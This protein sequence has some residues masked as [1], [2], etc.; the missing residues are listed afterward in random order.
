M[1]NE[2]ILNGISSTEFPGLLIQTLPP[3]VK[4]KM[5]SNIETIDG[6]DGDM[7]TV[8][9][10]SSYEKEFLIGLSYKYN[11]DDIIA[12]LN[13]H[14][15]V[16]FSNE[17]GKYYRYQILEQIDFEKLIRFK[18][19]RVKMHVQPFKYSNVEVQKK[20]LNN[21]LKFEDF[22]YSENG[23]TISKFQNYMIFAQGNASDL[24]EFS[25]P[26]TNLNIPVGTYTLR[27]YANGTGVSSCALS[28]I[29]DVPSTENT[30]G[31]QEI[32]LQNDV[33]VPLTETI[34]EPKEYNYLHLKFEPNTDVGFILDTNFSNTGNIFKVRNSGNYFSRPIFDIYG[35]GKIKMKINLYDVLEINLGTERNIQIDTENMDASKDGILKNRIVKGDYDNAILNP[36]E[37]TIFFDGHVN[38]FFVKLYSRWI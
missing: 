25:I 21:L 37:N 8:L 4:P 26:I 2:I 15:T 22:E 20:F 23:I 29:Y 34:A 12:F 18:T 16:T 5:R 10:Y 7:V 9:G 31:S 24:T 38:N 6:R 35:A 11:I 17:S 13:T 1:I 30:F 36:G 14:G 3:I 33:S 28:L 32:S 19:A 27:G